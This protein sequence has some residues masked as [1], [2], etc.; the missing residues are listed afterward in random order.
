MP[1]EQAQSLRLGP[2]L[3]TGIGLLLAIAGTLAAPEGGPID[4]LATR[5]FVPL[6][7]WLTVGAVAALS[8]ASLIFYAMSLTWRRLRKK[9]EDD[10]EL[11]HEPQKVT[12]I[13]AVFLILLALTPG[14]ILGGTLYWLGQSDVSVFPGHGGLTADAPPSPA[15]RAIEEPPAGPASPVTTGLIGTLA[16]L[17]S[18]G[19]LGVVLW[20]C[21]ADRLHRP[22]ADLARRHGPLAAAVEDSLEDLRREPD[23]RAA[24]I[25][26]YRNFERVLAAAALPRRTWQTPGEFMRAVLGK[27]PLPPAP[28]RSLTGLFERAR[29]S[30]HPVGAAERESA[31]RSLI[32]IR[33]ALDRERQT[34]DAARS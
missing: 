18:F 9:G 3:A 20:L 2:K 6:P 23:A 21:V 29:F 34:P 10:F 25:K 28:I 33:A 5:V 16:L 22:P 12:P 30:Q 1:P 4:G 32:E 13:L 7:D 8:L 19:S 14:A 17:A 31:W 27:S 15:P 26:I 24:I 11:Y